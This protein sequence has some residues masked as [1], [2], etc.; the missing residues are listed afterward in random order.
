MVDPRVLAGGL[1]GWG[2]GANDAGNVFGSAV[3]SGMV[4]WRTAAGLLAVFVLLGA[5]LGGRHGLETYAGLS[6]TGLAAAFRAALGAGVAILVMT[7]LR[8]PVSTSQAVVGAILGAALARGGPVD[9]STLR[10]VVACWVTAP[11]GAAVG[12]GL[13]Y[14][15]L[16]RVVRA[17]H[18]HFLFYDRMMRALLLFAGIYG[19]YALGAN[20]V[21]NA[22]GMFYRTGAFGPAGDRAAFLALLVGGASIGLGAL[23]FSRRVMSTVGARIVEFDAFSAFIVIVATA[24]TVHAYAWIGVPVSTS[25]A[26]VGAVCGVGLVKGLRTVRGRMLAAIALGWAATPAL[27]LGA[28]YALVRLAPGAH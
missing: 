7:A 5:L 11:V 15:A 24:G 26:A 1:L 12:A 9:L 3:G 19:A 18:P 4:R 23:T 27:G 17:A 2:L 6:G 16:A 8:L 14:P 28:T 21:A 13:L 25:Q 20:N 10:K 22:T